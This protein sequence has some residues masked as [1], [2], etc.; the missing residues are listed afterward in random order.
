MTQKEE[1]SFEDFC[2]EMGFEVVNINPGNFV[3]CDGCNANYTDRDTLGG[4]LLSR[5]AFCPQCAV[6][7]IKSAKKYKEE[8]FLTY[9]KKGESFKDFVLRMRHTPS[10]YQR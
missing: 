9:P 4:V 10:N 8:R 5:S 2:K 6:E 3:I 1:Q 7:I